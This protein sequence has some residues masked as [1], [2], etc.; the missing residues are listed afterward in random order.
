MNCFHCGNLVTQDTDLVQCL[1]RDRYDYDT[2]TIM[3]PTCFLEFE[4]RRANPKSLDPE[5]RIIAHE[6]VRPTN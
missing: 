3:H 6:M 2:K 4:K 1:L 5:Y